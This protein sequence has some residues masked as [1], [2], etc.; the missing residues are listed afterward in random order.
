[1]KPMPFDYLPVLKAYNNKPSRNKEV[2]AYIVGMG[3]VVLI[4]VLAFYS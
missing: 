1:M 4:V 2:T 3:I